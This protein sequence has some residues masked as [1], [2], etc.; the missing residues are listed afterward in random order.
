[1]LVVSPCLAPGHI[2]AL[3]AR[4][5]NNVLVSTMW[6]LKRLTE[7]QLAAFDSLVVMNPDASLDPEVS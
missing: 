6:A 1:M 3:G 7:A 2:G 4:G 5:K